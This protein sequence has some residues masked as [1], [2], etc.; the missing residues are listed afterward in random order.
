[1][2]LQ[3]QAAAPGLGGILTNPRII[4][5]AAQLLLQLPFSRRAEAEADLIGLK[6]MALAGYNPRMAPKTFLLIEEHQESGGAK[7]GVGGSPIHLGMGKKG[8][9]AGGGNGRSV[10]ERERREVEVYKKDKRGGRL[11]A[12]VVQTHP[13]SARRAQML[14]EELEQMVRVGERGAEVV[15]TKVPYW[16]L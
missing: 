12:T 15:L 5:T 11:P 6:L 8:K 3:P 13:R 4:N 9:E 7:G 1:L 16:M 10:P 2:S 14:E